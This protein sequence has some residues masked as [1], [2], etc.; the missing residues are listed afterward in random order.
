MEGGKKQRGKEFY[1]GLLE[2][3]KKECET[4]N[5]KDLLSTFIG[6]LRLEK[7]RTEPGSDEKVLCLTILKE[8]KKVKDDA[9]PTGIDIKA[10]DFMKKLNEAN[11]NR[12]HNI[13]ESAFKAKTPKPIEGQNQR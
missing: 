1:L 10:D 9:L 5:Q 3:L 4:D 12:I 2:S 11:F 8:A 7:V 13:I 6:K